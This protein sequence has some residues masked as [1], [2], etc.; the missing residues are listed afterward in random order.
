M[1][2]LNWLKEVLF[3]KFWIKAIALLLAF[4]VVFI[5]YV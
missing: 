2:F 4:L 5:L 1:K 3:S